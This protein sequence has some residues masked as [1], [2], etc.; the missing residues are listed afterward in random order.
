MFVLNRPASFQVSDFTPPLQPF[1]FEQEPCIFS[2]KIKNTGGQAG[3]FPAGL[4]V[5]QKEAQLKKI[6]LQPGE[7]K[8]ARFVFTPPTAGSYSISIG[9]QPARPGKPGFA[10]A[11]CKPTGHDIV[12]LDQASPAT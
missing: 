1:V 3:I 12:R 6:S 7:E 11:V 10:A 2:A 9:H 5:D 8:E 4:Y